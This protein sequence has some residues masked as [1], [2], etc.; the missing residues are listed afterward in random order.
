[1]FITKRVQRLQYLCDYATF[2]NSNKRDSIKF[3][4]SSAGYQPAGGQGAV[5]CY[6]P[7]GGREFESKGL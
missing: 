5:G 4:L 2:A 7:A 3:P 6:P 1:M